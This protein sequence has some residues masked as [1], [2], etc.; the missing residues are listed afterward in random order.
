MLVVGDDLGGTFTLRYTVMPMTGGARH[1]ECRLPAVDLR[2]ED[3]APIQS[4]VRTA[5]RFVAKHAK[6]VVLALASR[7]ASWSTPPAAAGAGGQ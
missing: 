5:G 7:S 4:G 1:A 2:S 3:V 6:L